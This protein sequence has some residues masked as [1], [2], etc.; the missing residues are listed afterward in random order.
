M[1]IDTPD[2]LQSIKNPDLDEAVDTSGDG[3]T[4]VTDEIGELLID[5]YPE[6][7]EHDS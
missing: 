7:T 1:W 4:Q 2:K 5:R 3:A 6:I